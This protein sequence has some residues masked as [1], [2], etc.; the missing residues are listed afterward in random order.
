[1]PRRN[2]LGLR[3]PSSVP[4]LTLGL[5]LRA[6]SVCRAR[7]SAP[8]QQAARCAR[9][10][11]K[12]TCLKLPLLT[13]QKQGAA[14]SIVSQVGVGPQQPCSKDSPPLLFNHVARGLVSTRGVAMPLAWFVHRRPIS[15]PARISERSAAVALVLPRCCSA[16]PACDGVASVAL[17]RCATLR[18][19]SNRSEGQRTDPTSKSSI[20]ITMVDSHPYCAP[21]LRLYMRASSSRREQGEYASTVC[22]S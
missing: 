13:I 5:H 4:S 20:C 21:Q 12:A 10:C 16:D 8:A 2:S 11:P 7:G 9:A 18:T 6:M 22:E 17:A 15:W 1:M 3:G 19:C 14:R